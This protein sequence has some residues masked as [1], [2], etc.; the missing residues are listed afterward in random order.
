MKKGLYNGLNYK[1]IIFN[2][3]YV[4]FI[5]LFYAPQNR[6]IHKL[7]LFYSA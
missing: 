4:I 3:N 5:F 2:L 1:I 7:G 6:I